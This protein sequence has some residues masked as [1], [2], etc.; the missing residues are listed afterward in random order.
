MA[1]VEGDVLIVSI[2][3]EAWEMRKQSAKLKLQ[4]A[5]GGE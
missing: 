4:L 5:S 3:V 1:E 2:E